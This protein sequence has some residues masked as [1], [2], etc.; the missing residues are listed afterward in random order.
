MSLII[1]L[2]S[3]KIHKVRH[4][5][6]IQVWFVFLYLVN[7]LP[8]VLPVGDK[9]FSALYE[10]VSAMAGGDLSS[11]APAWELLTPGNWL[12]LG[13]MLLAQ[14]ITV[15]VSFMYATLIVGEKEGMTPAQS[16]IRCLKALPRLLLFVALVAV[17]AIMSACL[18][19][20]PLLFFVFMM[21]FFPLNLVFE[22][23]NIMM[24]A[25][26]SYNMTR[27]KRLSIFFKVIILS[28]LFSLPQSVIS[29]VVRAPLAYYALNTFFVVLA[30]L[31]QARLMGILYLYLVKKV[32]FVVPSKPDASP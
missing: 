2:E 19:F 14:L 16:V 31:V 30:A 17:P 29:S 20:I 32:P 18:A 26:A 1:L 10:A 23:D 4:E 8:L 13:L 25:Q 3:I 28:F 6:T 5:R 27:G 7:I 12:T 9:D 24:A 11:A 15:Y 21:Y 22:N